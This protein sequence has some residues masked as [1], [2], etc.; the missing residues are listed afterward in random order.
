MGAGGEGRT[1]VSAMHD[2]LACCFE[3]TKKAR[4]RGAA[5]RGGAARV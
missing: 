5:R 4:R 3:G 2:V 1:R